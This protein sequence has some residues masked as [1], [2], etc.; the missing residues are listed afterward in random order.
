MPQQHLST[1]PEFDRAVERRRDAEWLAERL[2]DP[3]TRVV[4]VWRE[5]NLVTRGDDPR[6]VLLS[7]ADAERFIRAPGAPILLGQDDEAAYFAVELPGDDPVTEFDLRGELVDLHHIGARLAPRDAAILAHARA[8]TYWHRRHRFCGE[9]GAET[10]SAEAG[11]LRICS[12]QG[13]A[14]L[15]FP[16]VDPC[17]IV[18]VSSGDRCLLVRQP[19]W[20]QGRYSSIFGFVEPGESIEEAVVRQ[21][22]QETGVAVTDVHY[23][24]SHP[25]P[26]PSALM[27]GLLARA[28]DE[29]LRPNASGP[30]DA[31][32]FSRD[33][34]ERLVT[35]NKLLLPSDAPIALALI[36]EW[37][38]A[39]VPT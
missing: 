1:P 31:R 17:V 3:T 12:R 24:A 26:F 36:R 9:C 27:L 16:R 20:P 33:E 39:P 28:T 34:L 22:A 14:A 23:R 38:D 10:T 30:D 18:L 21:V 2:T 19:S 29:T 11:H 5:R 25:W 8:M 15:H 6:P 7:L 4:P 37:L 35:A 13:C 32:W